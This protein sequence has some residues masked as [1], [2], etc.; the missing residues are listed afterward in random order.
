MQVEF[1]FDFILSQNDDIMTHTKLNN[2]RKFLFY[3]IKVEFIHIKCFLYYFQKSLFA[4]EQ[5]ISDLSQHRVLSLCSSWVSAD[6]PQ[7]PNGWCL[8]QQRL[9][10]E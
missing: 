5:L 2:N 7:P 4:Q 10:E 1:V 9:R 6:G 8:H 3:M